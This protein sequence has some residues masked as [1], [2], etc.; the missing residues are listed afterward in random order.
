VHAL[1]PAHDVEVLT[2]CALDYITWKNHYPTGTTTEDGVAVTRFANRR[3]RDVRR[4]GAISDAGVLTTTTRRPTSG[5]GFW[6]TA[7]CA[8]TW[9]R[10]SSRGA[11]S[12]T[13]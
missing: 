9:S 3:E 8:R 7:R 13:S 10:P 11:T 12:I 1:R 6:R 2:T 5:S 4:F